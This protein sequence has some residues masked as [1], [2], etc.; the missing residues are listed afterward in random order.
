[1]SSTSS[2]L[3]ASS[4]V[5]AG[6]A[7]PDPRVIEGLGLRARVVARLRGEQTLRRLRKL[8]LRAEI[9]VRLAARSIIDPEFAWAVEIGAYTIIANDVRIVAHDAAIKRLTGYT[10]VRRVV[11]GRRCYIGAGSVI[12]PGASIGD[13]AV[14]GAGALVRGDIPPGSL[15]VGVPARVLGTVADLRERHLAELESQ[16]RFER[17]PL[18]M[19]AAER[20]AMRGAL[21]AHGRIYVR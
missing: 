19:S 7:L 10:E 6:D 17:R 15:A 20:D 8:G 12:L 16:P 1:M 4:A 5:A 14:I 21:D 3:A 2:H 9:P 18:D 13:E 11:I